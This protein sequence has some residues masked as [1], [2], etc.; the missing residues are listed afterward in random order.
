MSVFTVCVVWEGKTSLFLVFSTTYW[1]LAET[2][3]EL[4]EVGNFIEY[5]TIHHMH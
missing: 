2:T 3:D 5:K 1:R 4:H